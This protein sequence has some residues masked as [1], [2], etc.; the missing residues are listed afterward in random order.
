MAAAPA[1]S[2]HQVLIDKNEYQLKL[3]TLL[4]KASIICVQY[5]M[6][7]HVAINQVMEQNYIK[8]C[9]RIRKY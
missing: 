8:H 9:Y 2:T 7:L 6:I 1:G 4:M 5:C 3:V